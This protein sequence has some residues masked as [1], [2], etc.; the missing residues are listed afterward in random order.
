M[1]RTNGY[2]SRASKEKQIFALGLLV[3][4]YIPGIQMTFPPVT[5]PAPLLPLPLKRNAPAGRVHQSLW[6]DL[7]GS[8]TSKGFHEEHE[9]S[10]RG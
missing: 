1:G 2:S 3:S 4:K 6:D 8:L 10:P 7:H 5:L 9:G